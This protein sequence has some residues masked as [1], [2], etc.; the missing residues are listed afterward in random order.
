MGY[1]SSGSAVVLY[2]AMARLL[3]HLFT[4][5]QYGIFRDELYNL[6]CSQHLDWG[7]IDHPPA[8]DLIAW[9]ARHVFGESLL[10]LRFLPALAGAGLIVLTGALTREMGGG[11]FAQ[12]MSALAVFCVPT[13]LI[14][15]HF[16]NI[17]AFE[18]LI[19]MG[20]VWCVLRAINRSNPEC[21]AS[22]AAW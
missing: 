21:V 15:D 5:S 9:F 17:N 6:A 7:G 22:R 14:T 16:L 10:G 11:R 13:Y 20:C 12:A 1:F 8:I 18:P 19:W 2:V 4:A 3:L